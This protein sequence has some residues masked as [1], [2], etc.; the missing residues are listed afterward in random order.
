MDGRA[1]KLASQQT[2]ETHKRAD[3]LN[4]HTTPKLNNADTDANA[5]AIAD[6]NGNAKS[7]AI[8]TLKTDAKADA[9]SHAIAITIAIA[10]AIEKKILPFIFEPQTTGEGGGVH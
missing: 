1:D 9:K 3:K 10:T 4:N 2:S 6:A 8:A 7:S 5:D